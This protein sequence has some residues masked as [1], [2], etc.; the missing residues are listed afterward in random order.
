MFTTVFATD[1]NP[2]RREM[3]RQHGAVPVTAEELKEKVL[4][5]T[6]GRGADAALD[7]VGGPALVNTC[8]DV[9]RPYGVVSSIGMQMKRG[10]ID[11]P[12]LY[13]KK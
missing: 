3:A 6:E 2:E 7:L 1:P 9:I 12:L 10:D 13:S 5:A 4:K 8:L 11:Y